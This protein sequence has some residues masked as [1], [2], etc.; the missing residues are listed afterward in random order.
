MKAFYI[1]RVADIGLTI[2]TIILG[3]TLGTFRFDGDLDAAAA[4][5][6][7]AMTGV[8]VVGG[9]PAL[10]RGDGQERPVPAP[11]VAPRRHGGPHT[12]VG[13]D[14]RGHHGHRRR[15][16]DRADFPVLSSRWQPAPAPGSLDRSDHPA[17]NRVCSPWSQDD[18][19]RVLAYSTV[20]QLGYMMAAARGRRLHRRSVPSVDPRLLQGPALPRCGVGDPR[21]PL[22][23]HVRDGGPEEAHARDLPDMHH[24]RRWPWPASSPWLGSSRRTRSWRP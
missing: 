18:I 7:A 3:I 20:S 8:A 21:R 14:A 19:K 11:R 24:R 2:G 15:L 16:P 4:E 23:Q 12:G 9:H 22:Q 6:A 10:L 1:N 13:P 17:R 5:G